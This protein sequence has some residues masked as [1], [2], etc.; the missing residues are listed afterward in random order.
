MKHLL[1]VILVLGLVSGAVSSPGH[2][3]GVRPQPTDRS[4][5]DGF[6]GKLALDWE[7]LHP[8]STHYSLSKKPGCLTITTQE[9]GFA[10]AATSYKNLF[11]IDVPAAGDFT[12][13]TCISS[14]A[15]VADWNQAGLICYNDDD[16]N[17]KFVFEHAG[18]P[19]L[20]A[21]AETN[22]ERA[23]AYFPPARQPRKTIV[24]LLSD[25]LG[26]RK[27]EPKPVWLCIM[28]H[29]NRYSFLASLDGRAYRMCTSP[30]VSSEGFENGTINWGDGAV[31][32][33]GLFAKNGPMSSAPEIDASF[34]SFHSERLP[35]RPPVREASKFTIPEENREIP[36]EMQMCA[37]NFLKIRDAIDQYKTDKGNLPEWLSDLVPDYIDQEN[38]LCANDSEQKDRFWPDPKLPCSYTYEFSLSRVPEEWGPMGNRPCREWKTQ[39]MKLFGDVVPIVR[40]QHHGDN[41]L[42]LSVG[43]DLYCRPGLWETLFMPDYQWGQEF[44]LKEE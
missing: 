7:I 29:G 18:S 32:K 2:A 37:A 9:G 16:N 15:P 23:S 22:G 17:L 20:T 36:V 1:A 30:V 42:N 5:S 26:V 33:V 40:C 21:L 11:L 28:K 10:E 6:E 12:I 44:S 19:C 25:P 31:K 4:I 35:G 34:D 13:T 24:R 38:L 41:T 43:G 8:D 39:Q 14:F 27:E 3:E